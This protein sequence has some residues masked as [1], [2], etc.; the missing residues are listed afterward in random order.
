MFRRFE[1]NVIRLFLTRRV[2]RG[3]V[4]ALAAVGR[5]RHRESWYAGAMRIL[6]LVSPRRFEVSTLREI[7][8]GMRFG[9]LLGLLSVLATEPVRAE[10]APALL[11]VT[12]TS[13]RDSGLLDALLPVFLERDGVRV[14]VVAIGSGAAL[15]MGGSGRIL[16]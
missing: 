3:W 8:N 6:A 2:L 13:V 5:S 15:K 7:I 16:L 12:T 10:S 14:Q 9:I 11:L 1:R 4:F